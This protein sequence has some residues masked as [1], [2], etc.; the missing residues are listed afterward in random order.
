MTLLLLLK[1]EVVAAV[2]VLTYVFTEDAVGIVERWHL[3][4]LDDG[5]GET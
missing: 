1:I 2:Y 3:R 4:R 5:K